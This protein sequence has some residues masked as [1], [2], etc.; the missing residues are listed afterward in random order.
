MPLVQLTYPTEKPVDICEVREH[1][2]LSDESRDVELYSLIDQA[3]ESVEMI[4]G[5]KLM[6][7]TMRLE[8]DTFPVGNIDL[9][10]FP[11]Q[12]ISSFKYYDSTNVDTTL[13]SGTNYWRQIS[14]KYP[15]VGPVTSWPTTYEGRLGAVRIE[16]TVGYTSI[17]TVPKDIKRAILIQIKEW[18]DRGDDWI[19]GVYA[20]PMRTVNNLLFQHKRMHL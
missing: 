12:S 7:Q 6:T 14:G 11:V 3:T 2:R 20:T 10:V 19:L 13:V 4:L 5:G 9:G 1:L 8:L 18:F 17:D 15:Y 16:M